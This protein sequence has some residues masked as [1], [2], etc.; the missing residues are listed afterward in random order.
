MATGHAEIDAVLSYARAQHPRLRTARALDFGC[1]VGRL[2]Q[3]LA[4]HFERV[5]A[6]DIS[7][8]MLAMAAQL[9][10]HGERCTYRRN[11]RQDLQLF[12]SESFDFVY[13]AITLQHMPPR[14]A[15][16]YLVELARVTARDGLLIFQ[17]PA[18]LRR[19]LA[20]SPNVLARVLGRAWTAC[21]RRVWLL[22][23]RTLRGRPVMDMF[24]VPRREVVR[25]LNDHGLEVLDVIENDQA[26]PDWISCRYCARK[27][28]S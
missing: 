16:R 5:D 9:N 20:A 1:G 8:P 28:D 3:A 19:G 17:L 24:A 11:T 2:T 7:E 4:R 27:R 6:V 25:L 10:A 14:V 12:A 26:G 23:Q 21:N 13:S 22:W 15:R 18:G